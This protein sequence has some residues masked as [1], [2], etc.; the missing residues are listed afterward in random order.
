MT[1]AVTKALQVFILNGH[2]TSIRMCVVDENVVE[3]ASIPISSSS[4]KTCA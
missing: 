1:T 4:T 2:E 3:D